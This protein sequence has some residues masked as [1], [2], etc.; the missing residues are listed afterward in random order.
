MRKLLN[1]LLLKFGYLI[2]KAPKLLAE[3]S[4]DANDML[5]AE[6]TET[7]TIGDASETPDNELFETF[8]ADTNVHKWHHYFDIYTR[9]FE[10]MRHQ[11]YENADI[12]FLMP[13]QLELLP[14]KSI[15]LFIN[16][17]SLHEMRMDQIRYYFKVMEKL[18]RKYFYTKQWK[19]TTI[20]YEN[21][22]IRQEDYPVN[23]NWRQIYARE[24]KVQDLFFEALYDLS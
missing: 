8:A 15:D 11:E 13:H 1:K 12:V 7:V 21:V 9:H 24:C 6:L 3:Q 14:D 10:L 2:T 4:I 20:P 17:S 5:P 16:I 18:T 22:V 19:Q 23:E